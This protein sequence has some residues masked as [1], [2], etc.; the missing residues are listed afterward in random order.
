MKCKTPFFYALAVVLLNIYT[1]TGQVLISPSG[2]TPDADAMLEI[3][4]TD[5]GLLI[6]RLTTSQ[7]NMISTPA[8]GLLIFNSNTNTF[9][10]WNG[11][12]W[13]SIVAGSIKELS[14]ADNDT[15][16]EVEKIADEDKIRLTTA[17]YEIGLLDGKTFH[18]KSPGQSVF[19]GENA[20]LND[21]G[22]SNLNVFVG[23]QSGMSNTIGNNNTFIGKDAGA[24]N[25]NGTSNTFIGQGAGDMNTASNNTFIGTDAGGANIAGTSNTFVGQGAGDVNVGNENT[26][27]GKD[28][29]GANTVGT[30]NTFVG[31]GAG[32]TNIADNNTFVGKD[33]GLINLT[34]FSNTFV[35]KSAGAGNTSGDSN[36]F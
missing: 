33:A 30:A 18:L 3:T 2:G 4:A 15:K 21:D 22:T 12:A 29:G 27:I 17:G 9:N 16:I 5:K 28:A 24:A 11:T 36:T 10:Y 13:I 6:P 26:F 34:G 14:D 20:G 31:Q 8:S 1:V 19:I 7:R 23:H 35:G 32:M 25:V